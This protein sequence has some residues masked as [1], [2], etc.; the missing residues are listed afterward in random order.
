LTLS[1]YDG[2]TV[3]RQLRT[4]QVLILPRRVGPLQIAALY[5]VVL[6]RARVD[7]FLEA[8]AD[9]ASARPL[10]AIFGVPVRAGVQVASGSV[11]GLDWWTSRG[12]EPLSRIEAEHASVDF[13]SGEV[14]LRQ[15]RMTH[16]PTGRTI[17]APRAI[18]RGASNDLAIRGEYVLRVGSSERRGRGLRID[19]EFRIP[20]EP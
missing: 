19:P 18:W 12:G 20:S 6:T 13:R 15:L 2:S 14:A 3:T 17:E 10:A 9:R 5:E 16:L 11:F 1:E 7:V 8:A 4:N